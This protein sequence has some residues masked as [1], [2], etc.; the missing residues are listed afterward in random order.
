MA[1]ACKVGD[2]GYENLKNYLGG[3][4]HSFAYVYS[5]PRKEPT[6]MNTPVNTTTK[7]ITVK[8]NI[9]DGHR[10]ELE[11]HSDGTFVISGFFDE[12]GQPVKVRVTSASPIR[13]LFRILAETVVELK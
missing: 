5:E 7:T 10:V 3:L 12:K 2:L 6:E 9:Q 13:A 11:K 1:V 4:E 8:S